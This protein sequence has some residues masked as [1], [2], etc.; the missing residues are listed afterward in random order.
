MSSIQIPY[1]FTPRTYQTRIL[2]ARDEGFRRILAVVHRRG[3][4]DKTFLNMTI[5]EMFKRVGVYWYLAPTYALGKKFIWDNIGGDGF[6]LLDHFPKQLVVSK[7]EQEMKITVSNGSILQVIGTDKAGDIVGPNPV[8]CV[9]SEFSIMDPTAYNMIRPILREN[10]GWAAFAYTPRGRNHGYKLF[11]T[12]LKY[13][14][15]WY[16]E[17][18]TCRDTLRDSQGDINDRYMLPVVSEEDIEEE[19]KEGMDEELIQQEYYCSWS[20]YLQGSYYGK[21]LQS[22][23]EQGHFGEFPWIPQIPVDTW[24]DIGQSDSTAIWYTQA[25]GENK[26]NVI[27]YDEESGEGLPFYAKLLR[28]KPYIYGKHVFPWDMMVKE[29]GSGEIRAQTA[30]QLGIRPQHIAPKRGVH[31]GIDAVRKLLPI[32]YFDRVNCERGIYALQSYHKEWDE[33]RS[34]FRQNPVHDWAS[35]GADG[36]RTLGICN[37]FRTRR[38]VGESVTIKVES[39]YN[40]LD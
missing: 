33:K 12:A 7:N 39:S 22:I 5:K 2:R 19:R 16:V 4:K 29:F 35:H 23:E 34:E 9:F 1:H 17:Y 13:P 36:F 32:C 10:R 27:D 24:W 21:L 15:T 11:Q 38:M 37:R 28:E 40:E 14:E 6:K 30:R 31:E 3:G 8:G 20:G 25:V 26:I 18:L